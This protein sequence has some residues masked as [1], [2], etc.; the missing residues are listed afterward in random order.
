[1]RDGNRSVQLC[2]LAT[3]S[4]PPDY[5]ELAPA[6]PL[7]GR[8][9]VDCHDKDVLET[10]LTAAATLSTGSR[11]KI[12]AFLACA[13]HFPPPAAPAAAHG[14]PPPPIANLG[15]VLP[16]RLVH[17]LKHPEKALRA[18]AL[19]IVANVC[20][21]SSYVVTGDDSEVQAMIDADLLPQ[22]LMM[23][24]G[25]RAGARDGMAVLL[26]PPS[27]EDGDGFDTAPSA[28]Q[29]ATTALELAG[30]DL[31]RDHR[32]VT[33]ALRVLANVVAGNAAQ[34]EAV[35]RTDSASRLTPIGRFVPLICALIQQCRFSVDFEQQVL[36]EAVFV[37]NNTL[38]HHAA[39]AALSTLLHDV[40]I[41]PFL[42]RPI[43]CLFSP[44]V[45]LSPARAVLGWADTGHRTRGGWRR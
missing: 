40:S 35:L 21:A 25:G 13:D 11:E 45:S 7:L 44:A 20:A 9:L 3:G 4:P 37:L 41:R 12:R 2:N 14:A 28:A 27:A 42:I 43:L 24:H 5:A 39:F 36:V 30:I 10:A 29:P 19:V 33:R 23:L 18:R 31:A 17:L 16:E 22:L 34:F 26:P 15:S 6:L 8:L 32:V 38:A 1:M